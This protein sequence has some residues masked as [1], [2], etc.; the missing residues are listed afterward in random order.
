MSVCCVNINSPLQKCSSHIAENWTR[1][2]GQLVFPFVILNK[3]IFMLP[4]PELQVVEP[5]AV[6]ILST[7]LFIFRWVRLISATCW[8]LLG[9]SL[10]RSPSPSWHLESSCSSQAPGQNST[11]SGET[12]WSVSFQPNLYLYFVPVTLILL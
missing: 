9:K 6:R 3:N 12:H 11:T 8:L 2:L 5:C 1:E 4:C 10:L 7:H